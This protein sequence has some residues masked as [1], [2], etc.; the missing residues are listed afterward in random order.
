M[1][2]PFARL[3]K[4]LSASGF[5]NLRTLAALGLAAIAVVF[6]L[7]AVGSTPNAP[8]DSNWSIVTSPN[9]ND[10]GQDNIIADVA[11]ASDNDCWSVGYHG[12]TSTSGN[13][14]YLYDTIVQHWD[15]SSWSI[16][17]SP[18]AANSISDVLNAVTCR[19]TS[20]CWAVGSYATAGS[21]FTQI[22]TEHWNGSSWSVVPAPNV[23][24]VDNV[25][26]DV[27][28]S[29]TVCRGVGYSGAP[30]AAQTLIE[31]WNG[32]AWI[33]EPSANAGAGATSLRSVAC[34]SVTDC[35]AVGSS[36]TGSGGIEQTFVEHW[37]GA[38]WT[39]VDSPN[40]STTQ[41]NELNHLKCNSASDCWAVG[42]FNDGQRDNAL[43][44]HWDGFV[45]GIVNSPLPNGDLNDM[46]D[47]VT[48]SSGIDCWVVGQSQDANGGRHALSEHWNGSAWS[49]TP[50]PDG[51]GYSSLLQNVVCSSSNSCWAI[52]E[53]YP[54]QAQTL[55]ERWDGSVWVVI[56]SPNINQ[57]LRENVLNAVDCIS[58]SDCWAVG[59]HHFQPL[60]THWDGASW[61]AFDSPI[62]DDGISRTL[63]AVTCTSS[64]DCWAVGFAQGQS[65]TE[66]W[67]GTSWAIVSS[68]NS[69]GPYATG[70]LY[71]VA[72]N[73][74]TDCWAA[75]ASQ[76]PNGDRTLL[77]HWNGVSWS[78]VPSPDAAAPD[79]Y[80]SLAAITCNSSSN[81]W[82]VGSSSETDQTEAGHT[83]A[84]HWDGSAW[85][86]VASPNSVSGVYN[87]LT[88]VTCNVASD[89]WAVGKYAVAGNT[90]EQMTQHWDGSAW[91]VVPS[92]PTNAFSS[93]LTS[94]NC[95][96]A[97]NCFAV[98]SQQQSNGSVVQTLIE[99]WNGVSW[100]AVTSGDMSFVD[101]NYLYAVTCVPEAYCWTLGEFTFGAKRQTL[102]EGRTIT[103][104]GTP[105][106][107]VTVSP[108]QVTEG[109]AAT[110]VVSASAHTARPIAVSYSMS[111]KAIQ[112]SDY[113]L[114][115]V[116]GQVLIPIGTNSASIVLHALTDAI[117]EKKET[118]TMTLGAGNGYSFGAPVGKKKKAPKPPA[119]TVTIINVIP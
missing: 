24:G 85:S 58:A 62:P 63:N 27:A 49:L 118:A 14:F 19:S 107:G 13:V 75:G 61:Q 11:C 112:G 16:V 119:A 43:I 18:N 12:T 88:A 25:L 91:T 30:N 80:S 2:S 108:A 28:C 106:V 104:P 83:L 37:D 82:A 32:T 66:H 105:I 39:P 90:D 26:V 53:A 114:S 103:P 77:E 113:S 116:A 81:C 84:L 97:T 40:S 33:I 78:V 68:P 60:L 95:V 67:N 99:Q 86:V 5:S 69:A 96:S 35:W 20:D 4:S 42:H 111:G 10:G 93:W 46:F 36:S 92:A 98:G 87:Y 109:N 70:Y 21:G 79:N 89:C 71:G 100:T 47:G 51:P 56:D 3:S 50:T 15:G 57:A 64:N 117:K 52:G 101:A 110:F 22:L 55:T 9:V 54:Q 76:T 115:G 23:T 17:T 73:S 6:V 48:C 72:C 94:V 74:A 29:S 7:A 65:L 102:I 59:Y 8:T 44:Q 41:L 1:R 38:S 31:R 34:D 45:W